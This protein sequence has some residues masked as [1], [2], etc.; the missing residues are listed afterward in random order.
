MW[1]HALYTIPVAMVLSKITL[2]KEIKMEGDLIT[3]LNH[4]FKVAGVEDRL[5]LGKTKIKAMINAEYPAGSNVWTIVNEIITRYH[6]TT[7]VTTE[8]NNIV[9]LTLE[10]GAS[11][12]H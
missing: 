1:V 9:M 10:E 4:L 6:L 3:E 2:T 8:E 12:K 11:W 7:F 5:K